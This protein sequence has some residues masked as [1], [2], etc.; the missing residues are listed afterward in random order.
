MA[1]KSETLQILDLTDKCI[2]YEHEIAEL[3]VQLDILFDSLQRAVE[4]RFEPDKWFWGA[5]QALIDYSEYIKGEYN[6]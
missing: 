3:N 5:K 1:K 2:N 6:E 4:N